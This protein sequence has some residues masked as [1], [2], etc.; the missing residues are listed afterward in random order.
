MLKIAVFISKAVK[1]RELGTLAFMLMLTVCAIS[2]AHG[3]E[4]P[5]ESQ[6][7]CRGK[8]E[9]SMCS[10]V[11]QKGKESGTCAYTPDN[12][13][14]SCRPTRGGSAKSAAGEKRSPEQGYSIEQA[15]SDNAQLHTISFAALSFMSSGICEMSFLPPGKH[16]SYFGFQYLRDVVGGDAGH[17]Q[18]FVSQ[19]A[20]NLLYILSP[21]QREILLNLAE[22]Q[23]MKIDQ[24]A[25]QRFPLLLSFE[26]Y[27]KGQLPQGTTRLNRRKIVQHSGELY[28]LDGE[29][30]YERAIAFGRV[31]NSLTQDQKNYLNEFKNKPFD[32]WP[33]RVEQLN[34]RHFKHPIHV[35]VM[36]YASEL[37]SWYIGNLEK[38]VY[39]TP[40]RTA[41]Y[42]GAY[43]TKAAPMKAV[44]RGNYQISTK[45]T[46]D[47]GAMFLRMLNRQQQAQITNLVQRQKSFLMEMIGI[48][49]SIA[50]IIR[51]ITRAD[52]AKLETIVSLSRKFGALDGEIAYLYAD[53]Y[54]NIKTSLSQ[55]QL[56]NATQIRNISQYPCKGAFIYAEPSHIPNVENLTSFFQ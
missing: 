32:T 35:A 56:Q 23:R 3:R 54:T 55:S 17:G 47:S 18:N 13:F 41:A 24:F 25:L 21:Q 4:P 31:V 16:A 33:Q 6:A 37:L 45:L 19:V 40:E 30:S 34:K 39:F 7:A 5:R 9:G 50:T 44:R 10:F 1:R 51:N 49:K 53:T 14:Y 43:W 28:A 42:F 11:S 29:L 12:K 36:T 20:N 2:N 46:G 22:Q 48:R 8:P 27:A 52:A 38:D 26:R 15:T